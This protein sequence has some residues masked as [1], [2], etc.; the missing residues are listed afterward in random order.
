MQER[1]V[2]MKWNIEESISRDEKSCFGAFTSHLIDFALV[3]GPLWPPQFVH[4]FVNLSVS[5]S[6]ILRLHAQTLLLFL[7][8]MAHI[9]L[10]L[11]LALDLH[12]DL[13]QRPHGARARR[14]GAAVDAVGSIWAPQGVLRAVVS[15]LHRGG[16]G[17]LVAYRG[18]VAAAVGVVGGGRAGCRRGLQGNLP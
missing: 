9:V 17:G 15:V 4:L 5:S 14:A 11:L 8:C 10:F 7:F 2:E 6:P 13:V 18:D 3:A 1:T 16:V 12:A